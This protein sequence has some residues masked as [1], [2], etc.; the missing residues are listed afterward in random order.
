[1][2]HKYSS[3]KKN[4][5]SQGKTRTQNPLRRQK[6]NALGFLAK[7]KKEKVFFLKI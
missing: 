7:G 4:S 6:K 5:F 3:N 1:M 2:K